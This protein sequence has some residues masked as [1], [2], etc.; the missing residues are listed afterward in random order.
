MDVYEYRAKWVNLE[1]PPPNE[2]PLLIW[3]DGTE[4]GLVR[5]RW[6]LGERVFSAENTTVISQAVELRSLDYPAWFVR[7]DEGAWRRVDHTPMDA[8]KFGF[9][10]DYIRSLFAIREPLPSNLDSW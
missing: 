8:S 9:R 7:L 4:E 3:Q 5:D 2:Y 1:M 10:Q 6:G